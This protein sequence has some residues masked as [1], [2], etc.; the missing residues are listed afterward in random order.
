MNLSNY[1][2]WA[3][4]AMAHMEEHT[5]EGMETDDQISYV[6]A[7][8]TLRNFRHAL[9]SILSAA[10]DAQREYESFL[11]KDYPHKHAVELESEE[12]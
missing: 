7:Y 1:Y 8:Q 11:R 9:Q 2:L 6:I 5:C 3:T 10:D 12:E 4:D